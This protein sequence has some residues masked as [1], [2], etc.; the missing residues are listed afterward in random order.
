MGGM[1]AQELAI[2]YPEK[3]SKLVLCSTTCKG[4]L[5]NPKAARVMLAVEQGCCARAHENL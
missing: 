3:V 4:N 1:V 2:N 5:I